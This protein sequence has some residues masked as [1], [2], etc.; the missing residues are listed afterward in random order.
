MLS[1]IVAGL[2]IGLSGSGGSVSNLDPNTGFNALSALSLSASGERFLGEYKLDEQKLFSVE[3]SRFKQGYPVVSYKEGKVAPTKFFKTF[4]NILETYGKDCLIICDGDGC[5]HTKHLIN[6]HIRKIAKD[7]PDLLVVVFKPCSRYKDFNSIYPSASDNK[8]PDNV[9]FVS[10][11]NTNLISNTEFTRTSLMMVV[12]DG[13]LLSRK[14]LGILESDKIFDAPLTHAFPTIG[15][16]IHKGLTKLGAKNV[17]WILDPSKFDRYGDAAVG[18][19]TDR[20]FHD[21]GSDSRLL[22]KL[23]IPEGEML[24]LLKRRK[25]QQR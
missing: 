8:F 5:P 2:S 23:D 6:K 10:D 19:S 22:L 1:S 9:I 24:S 25:N 17:E 15:S 3:S 12:K 18:C 20:C 7:N 4:N 11:G 14:D 13:K 16:A 21:G